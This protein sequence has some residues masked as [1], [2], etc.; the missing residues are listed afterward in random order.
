MQR[1]ATALLSFVI[2]TAG[3]S[4][5]SNN[6]DRAADQITVRSLP[7]VAADDSRLVDS[8][9]REIAVR[10][11]NARVDGLFDVS[12]EDGRIALEPIPAF[13]REDAQDMVRYGFK[14]LRLPV[15]WSGMEPH[16]GEF[17]EAYFETL[18]RV[19]D[20][21]SAAGLYVLIDVHQDAWS[22]EIG[23]DGAPLWAIVPPPKQLL[24][25]RLDDLAARRVSTQVRNA[26]QGFFENRE[27]IQDRF[28][29][30]W[31]HLV[32]RYANRPEVIGFQPMN[33]PFVSH[34]D[35]SQKTLHD[36]YREILPPM[37]ELDDRHLLWLEP[38]VV[39]NYLNSAPLLEQLF[40]DEN[41]VYC[42][43][44]Y[45][46]GVDASTYEEWKTWLV[47][48][49]SSMR[50]EADSWGAALVVSEWGTHPDAAESEGYIRAQQEAAEA[51][52]SGQITWLWKEDSQGSWG[53][54]DVDSA[55][56]DWVLRENAV[57]H[58]AK[59]YAQAVPGRF[60]THNFDPATGVLSFSFESSGKEQGEA[61][62]YLPQHW[63][64]ELPTIL[65]NGST[66][67]YERDPQ[68]QRVLLDLDTQSGTFTVEV[69]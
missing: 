22:K 57:R 5:H 23:E 56:G 8:L 52:S 64:D 25:G 66:V 6:N 50:V 37:R 36:F 42:P 47:E 1:I 67:P 40:P 11:I 48:N 7:W 19:I 2:S 30:V 58:F 27:G 34:F 3:C 41:I 15:N 59:P 17:S 65:V 49:Y 16:E 55:T 10:G 9:G 51:L 44:I 31:K 62:L 29:P 28:L 69:Y 38:G 35:P 24:E 13:S 32:G 54:Y 43:H 18:D 26:F 20:L 4:D 14:V 21:A 63:F 45:P 68:T 53:F 12:F 39:R 60:L 61:L 46:S 33:E